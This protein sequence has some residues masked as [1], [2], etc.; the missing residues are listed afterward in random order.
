[1]ANPRATPPAPPGKRPERDTPDREV[2][3]E[4]DPDAPNDEGDA[5]IRRTGKRTHARERSYVGEAGT[6]SK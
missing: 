2:P 6:P 4:R 1:M 5:E 3:D